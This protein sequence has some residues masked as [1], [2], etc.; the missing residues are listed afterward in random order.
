MRWD[1]RAPEAYGDARCIE[2]EFSSRGDRVPAR[3]LLPAE[4]DGSARSPVVVLV[5]DAAGSMDATNMAEAAA[6]VAS[7][8]AVACIDLPLH[9]RRSSPKLSERLVS[10]LSGDAAPTPALRDEFIRQSLADLSRLID[11]T[12]A[13]PEIDAS[14]VA[15]AG[16]GLG[17]LLA[18]ALGS[19]DARPCAA[20]L[21]L[22]GATLA[23]RPAA[24]DP[25]AP[26]PATAIGAFAPR[27]L[28]M[29]NVE[30]DQRVPAASAQ[31]LFD[32]AGEP[33]T[34]HWYAGTADALPSE[35][36]TAILDFLRTHLGA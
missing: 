5:H 23:A 30:Q 14:R 4:G 20:A 2:L 28:L 24:D 21:A 9:G 27:P 29:V 19:V 34:L 33:K 10:L 8:L 22:S 36:S 3:V 13:L 7:G 12:A 16:F 25:A 35:A 26:D 6:W 11:A 17:G 15:A 32:A 18:A 1:T 31:A